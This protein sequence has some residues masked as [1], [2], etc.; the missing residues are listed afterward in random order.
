MPVP[1]NIKQLELNLTE[2]FPVDLVMGKLREQ[3]LKD[4]Q[5]AGQPINIDDH[6]DPKNYIGAVQQ[7]INSINDTTL[8]HLLYVIDLPESVFVSC[9]NQNDHYLLLAESI[10][11]REFV[12]VYY[13]LHFSA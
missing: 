12:K 1:I 3:L 4:F 11:Y 5:K 7:L 13:K 9:L 6:T 10:V 8:Q 2:K